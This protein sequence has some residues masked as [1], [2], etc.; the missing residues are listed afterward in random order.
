[1]EDELG[2]PAA[3]AFW[4][5]KIGARSANGKVSQ[6]RTCGRACTGHGPSKRCAVAGVFK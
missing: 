5:D 3:A 4:N 1:M 2:Q 6:L